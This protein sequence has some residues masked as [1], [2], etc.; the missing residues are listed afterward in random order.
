[1]VQEPE[2]SFDVVQHFDFHDARML[3]PSHLER[4]RSFGFAP[5]ALQP[6]VLLSAGFIVGCVAWTTG[7]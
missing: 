5:I 2:R 1:M 6:Y 3:F 4:V 7:Q